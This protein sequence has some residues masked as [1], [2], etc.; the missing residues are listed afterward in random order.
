MNLSQ[1][2][3]VAVIVM[4][5]LALLITVAPLAIWSHTAKTARLLEQQNALLRS[6]AERPTLEGRIAAQRARRGD[7]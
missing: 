7:S 5:V 3:P 6:L 4:V 2:A 1:L